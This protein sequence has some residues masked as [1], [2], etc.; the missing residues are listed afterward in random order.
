MALAMGVGNQVQIALAYTLN[1]ISHSAE[2]LVRRTKRLFLFM[3]QYAARVV[4]D[5]T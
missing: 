1:C 5:W 4:R 3:A 2:H